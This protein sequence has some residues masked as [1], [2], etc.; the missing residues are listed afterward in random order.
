[1][2]NAVPNQNPITTGP[3]DATKIMLRE[4]LQIHLH[5]QHKRKNLLECD[6]NFKYDAKPQKTLKR[7]PLTRIHCKD[8]ELLN[9]IDLQSLVIM[10][11]VLN[12]KTWSGIL[13]KK[14]RT[15]GHTAVNS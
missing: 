12:I 11:R 14:C 10:K 1:M 5:G 8:G 3:C 7:N 6:N 9:Y 15:T 4:H 2:F 13:R